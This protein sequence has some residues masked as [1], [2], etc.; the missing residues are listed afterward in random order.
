MR[1][2]SIC[3]GVD[4]PTIAWSKLGWKC[5][6]FTEIEP[7]PSA[8][9]QHHYPDVPNLGDMTTADFTP[10]IGKIDLLMASCPCQAFSVA[11]LRQGIKDARG[12][13]TLEYLKILQELRPRWTV[14]E[15]VPGIVSDKTHAFELLISGLRELGYATDMAV[16]NA[17]DFGLPQLRR[18]VFVVGCGDKN[19]VRQ[20]QRTFVVDD[21]TRPRNMAEVINR[22]PEWVMFP[23]ISTRR[24]SEHVGIT[25]VLEDGDIDKTH[26]MSKRCCEG[27]VRRADKSDKTVP[28]PLDSCLR[29][30][31]GMSPI[32]FD[33]ANSGDK[34]TIA[35]MDGQTNS[36]T[37]T[38][39]AG[40]LVA[41]ASKDA[42]I[43]MHPQTINNDDNQVAIAFTT[44]TR[45][46][47]RKINGDGDTAGAVLANP[48][49]KHH[50]YVCLS[51]GK[52]TIGAICARDGKGVGNQ[53]VSEGKTMSVRDDEH[54]TV[55]L[56]DGSKYT[57]RRMTPLECERLMGFPDDYTDIPWNGKEHSPK[58]L[59]YK[60]C[61]NSIAVPCVKWI[62]ERIMVAESMS[63]DGM[64]R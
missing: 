53:L 25:S 33:H 60:A 40:S 16:L 64:L 30:M 11:G 1:Y 50:N 32:H 56:P 28:E 57:L 12:N 19:M 3:S 63:K 54:G 55:T 42:P 41:H 18:R 43:I 52:D 47:A 39:V 48:G 58:T 9:L 23:L 35:K 2:G 27:I 5:S 10:Y 14:F 49:A 20:L 26:M 8:V 61:G 62:G 44:N 4:A 46:E 6:F 15:N 21:T 31:A 22:H 17:V 29:I 51:N 24:A 13:L 37:H 7:Y 45:N 59:R 34:K 38:D 36:S